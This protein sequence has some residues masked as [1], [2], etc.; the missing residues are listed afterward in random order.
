MNSAGRVEFAM[1]PPLPATSITYWGGWREPV[2]HRRL[3]AEIEL[4]A[5][6]RQDRAVPLFR[7]PA[8]DAEPTRPRCPATKIGAFLS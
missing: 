4:I 6:R 7:E 3:I 8:Q 5:R 2:V 1:M